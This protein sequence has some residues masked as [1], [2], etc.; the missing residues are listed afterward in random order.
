MEGSNAQW[1]AGY[2]L[3][4]GRADCSGSN[5]PRVFETPDGSILVQGAIRQQ[6]P[7][8]ELP[9]DEAMVEI[10]REVMDQVISRI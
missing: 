6:S 1:P 3:L 8:G 7:F 5:C 10:P 2:R 9:E 4:G